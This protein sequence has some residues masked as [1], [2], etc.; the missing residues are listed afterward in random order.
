[1]KSNSLFLTILFLCV[2]LC[3]FALESN[4]LP[5]FIISNKNDTTIGYIDKIKSN[6]E[7]CVFKVNMNFKKDTV[8]S[9]NDIKAYRFKEGGKFFV[10]KT[11]PFQPVEKVLFL[12]FIIKGKINIYF[13][14]DDMDHYFI[15]KDNINLV[16]LSERPVLLRDSMGLMYYRAPKFKGI[17]NYTL[18]D[19]PDIYSNIKKIELQPKP[20]I[21]LAKEYQKKV[22]D[23][24]QCIVFE[25]KIKEIKVHSR[26]EIG[27]NYS[28]I[29]NPFNITQTNFTPGLQMGFKINLDNVIFSAEQY[30]F[31]TGLTFGFYNNFER[32]RD[33]SN[34]N[35]VSKSSL[36]FNLKSFKVSLPISVIYTFPYHKINPYIGT[37]IVSQLVMS[38][39]KASNVSTY[40]FPF[41]QFGLLGL[42][43]LKF[44]LNNHHN[45][46][47]EVS[48]SYSSDFKGIGFV[49]TTRN[50]N[51]AATVGYE[52]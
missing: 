26:F 38:N 45:I 8:L 28:H 33:G 46:N 6:S 11:V 32:Y 43:G 12:E 31:Q 2:S 40:P 23:N 18:S 50:Q 39:E 13:Y 14:R 21:D 3:S 7:S 49:T 22:C 48:Y 37:G 41:L 20:L 35:W 30:S 51:I 25:R 29:V 15:E 10:S 47:F 1:M 5:G 19:C 36:D 27:L 42:A 17:L 9:P 16:E 34:I 44:D 24:E 4:F 52:L